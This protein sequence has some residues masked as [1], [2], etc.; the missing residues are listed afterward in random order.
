MK[1]K[2]DSISTNGKPG[3]LI[4]IDFKFA[5]TKK[6]KYESDYIYIDIC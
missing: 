5:R 2:L 4:N 1:F 6:S 3:E